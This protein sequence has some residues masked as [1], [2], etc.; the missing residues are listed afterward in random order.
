MWAYYIPEN[1]YFTSVSH[2]IKIW[3]IRNIITIKVH[4][5]A[6][7]SFTQNKNYVGYTPIISGKLYIDINLICQL[8][9]GLNILNSIAGRHYHPCPWSKRILQHEAREPYQHV[10]NITNCQ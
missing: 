9:V 3:C 8:M 2:I 4:M 1:A 7:C 5:I 10:N 6:V